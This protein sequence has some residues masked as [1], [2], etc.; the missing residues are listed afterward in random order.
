MTKNKTGF[1]LIELSVAIIIIGL[2]VSGV[3]AGS[4][5]I[6][7]AR[8]S[9][10][11]SASEKSPVLATDSLV[12]WMDTTSKNKNLA[13]QVNG[14]NIV[15]GEL[16][17]S[18]GDIN[19]STQAGER[20]SFVAT[21]NT[22]V[23]Y[24]NNLLNG[25]PAIKMAG[26]GGSS[27]PNITTTL[28]DFV[29][30]SGA[31]TIFFVSQKN[32]TSANGVSSQL[33]FNDF[34][35]P[36]GQIDYAVLDNGTVR[37]SFGHSCF[38]DTA[39]FA[40]QVNK[41]IIAVLMR[42]TATYKIRV[43]GLEHDFGNSCFEPIGNARSGTAN[44]YIGKAPNGDVFNGSVGEIIFFNRA[45]SDTEIQGIEKYLSLKWRITLG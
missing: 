43:N 45:L 14:Q 23:T 25:L 42:R 2:L 9:G 29:D 11:R 44:F 24:E 40:T 21:G 32:V 13:G 39:D 12:V 38:Q 15:F 5:M 34:I 30:P 31:G 4:S 1:S 36:W 16:L 17:S 18:W 3:V 28:S 33:F 26:A 10:A 20:K 7:I 6:K 19:P 41:P 35:S 37:S 22:S 8:L 27:R